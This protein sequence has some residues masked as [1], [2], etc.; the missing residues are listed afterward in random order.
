[1]NRLGSLEEP[2]VTGA[3]V[4]GLC[5]DGASEVKGVERLETTVMENAS[6]LFYREGKPDE[7]LRMTEHIKGILLSLRMRV[8]FR[9]VFQSIGGYE[10][11]LARLA[12]R[13]N[14]ENGLT[15]NQD[16]KLALIVKWTMDAAHVEVDQHTTSLP[17]FDCDDYAVGDSDFH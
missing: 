3:E 5:R 9:L 1:M 4:V 14:S 11:H 15:L 16:S 8:P 6:T 10:L 2:V 12:Q 17:P 7:P 13:D